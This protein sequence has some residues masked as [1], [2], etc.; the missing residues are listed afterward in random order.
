[1]QPDRDWVSWE[2]GSVEGD[3]LARLVEVFCCVVDKHVFLFV[4]SVHTRFF[5]FLQ[6]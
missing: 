2:G 4:R 6:V 5:I 3:Q 1:M